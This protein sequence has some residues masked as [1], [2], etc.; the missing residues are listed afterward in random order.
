MVFRIWDTKIK[1]DI[2]FILI[3]VSAA[4]SG[5]LHKSCNM[6]LALMIHEIGHIIAAKGLDY[7]IDK[8]HIL[9]IGGKIEIRDLDDMPIESELVV[10]L[11]GPMANFF[12]TIFLLFLVT[13]GF[14][15]FETGKKII[16]YQL[17][18]GFFNLLPALPLDGGRIFVLW[19]RQKLS[20]L[21]AIKI[22]TKTGK[23]ISTV[24][25]TTAIV[26]FFVQKAFVE[27][28]IMGVFLFFYANKE[29]KEAPFIF[30]KTTA[31]KWQIL[32]KQRLMSVESVVVIENT[33]V[34][35]IMYQFGP[36]KYHLIYLLNNKMGVEKR[37]TESEIFDLI[38]EK[39]LDITMKEL[40]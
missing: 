3:I 40:V 29:E 31:G 16:N 32:S 17:T 14:F 38:A 10:I 27:F 26:G 24:L 5:F 13:G 7:K 36:K 12:M 8:I 20:F 39:G 25:L 9:P 34:K 35:D 11:A 2:I 30:I 28:A 22:A 1:I 15:P 37:F 6:L 19:L 21:S 23:I 4:F 18:L 33:P